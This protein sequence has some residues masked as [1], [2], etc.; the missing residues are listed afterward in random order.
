MNKWINGAKLFL[1]SS[2]ISTTLNCG[3]APKSECALTETDG[4]NILGINVTA[5][6]KSDPVFGDSKIQNNKKVR[7]C[8]LV[9][10]EPTSRGHL[11]WLEVKAE[12]EQEAKIVFETA[13]HKP[14]DATK[15]STEQIGQIGDEARLIRYETKR[16]KELQITVRRGK[17]IFLITVSKPAASEI[18]FE[19]VKSLAERLAA[20]TTDY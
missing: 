19:Q 12:N 14:T 9:A 13:A 5:I 11:H 17:T 2:L 16:T 15:Y 8:G 7:A 4:E 10:Q 1:I 3:F 6:D 20:Q 18:P